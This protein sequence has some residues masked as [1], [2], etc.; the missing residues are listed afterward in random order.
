MKSASENGNNRTIA[1]I[2][3]IEDLD[4]PLPQKPK[5]TWVRKKI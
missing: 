2:Y 1:K 4:E 3:E 5:T